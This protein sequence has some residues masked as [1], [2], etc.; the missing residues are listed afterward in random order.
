MSKSPPTGQPPD[1]QTLRETVLV[2]GI[3][4][5]G[6]TW[7]GDVLNYDRRY[8]VLFEPLHPEHGIPLR[9]RLPNG[10]YL[11]PDY[12][13]PT[14]RDAVIAMLS[15]QVS[16]PWTDQY[17]TTHDTNR[18]L[19]KAIRLNLPLAWLRAQFPALPII[20]IMRHPGAVVS[21]QIRMG[22]GYQRTL[23][24]M[25][26][27]PALIEAHLHPFVELASRTL[28]EFEQ[29]VL[30]WCMVN[31]VVLRQLQ[32]GQAQVVCYEDLVLEPETR[33]KALFDYLGQPYEE[34]AV[35]ALN[36]KPSAT[37]WSDTPEANIRR[38]DRWQDNLTTLQ[39]DTML[40]LLAL[41]GLDRLY[42]SSSVPLRPWDE[43]QPAPRV[44]RLNRWRRSWLRR[45]LHPL[46]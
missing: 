10:T 9:E 13:D 44:D 41:F 2:T 30:L 11:P 16:T 38:L 26:T 40:D 23:R 1:D 21:S 32:P 24:L 7:L 4:R 22:W 14:L 31:Y 46:S 34:A 20:Y 39:I 27:Q 8:R 25:L 12:S 42:G 28:D 3:G 43:V 17:N 5:S 6:T 15:G 35:L 36:E 18:V 29:R 45:L 37:T 19:V 33:F